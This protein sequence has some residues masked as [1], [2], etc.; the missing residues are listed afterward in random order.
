MKGVAIRVRAVCATVAS[1]ERAQQVCETNVL[2]GL[3]RNPIGGL[4]PSAGDTVTRI[5]SAIS[6]ERQY[7]KTPWSY[8][9]LMMVGIGF[10]AGLC[11]SASAYGGDAGSAMSRKADS[12]WSMSNVHV[13]ELPHLDLVERS[14]DER[15]RLIRK[16]KV[17]YYAYLSTADQ[18]GVRKDPNTSQLDIDAEIGAMKRHGIRIRGWYFWLNTE[19]PEKDPNVK[20]T[21]EAF[22][23]HQIHPDIWLPQSYADPFPESKE[24]FPAN[25]DDQLRR[26]SKEADRISAMVNL[27]KQYG[28]RVS[29]YNHRGWYGI[30]DNQ[31]AI[32]GELNS[33][34]I[35]DVGIVYNLV[36][37]IS[38]DH[39]DSK[40]FEEL[41]SR[42]QPFVN[43]VNVLITGQ[44]EVEMMRT[45]EK[46]GWRGAI[47]LLPGGFYGNAE[48]TYRSAE[49]NLDWAASQI[50][51]GE[52]PKSPSL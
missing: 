31:L 20:R 34:G 3:A 23:R 50:E 48:H 40:N 10:Y 43:T 22:R 6:L 46:S 12:L 28:C 15:A 16:L 11:H 42:I 45:I 14:P 8:Y 19:T 29:L 47:G 41:W 44:R 21:L 49:W 39:D 33:R 5:A 2:S 36:H 35:M 18:Y 17:R 1:G 13:W 25:Q 9:K 27:A 38:A 24:G 51:T 26:V 52:R 4:K 32:L 7:M 30:L 37:S